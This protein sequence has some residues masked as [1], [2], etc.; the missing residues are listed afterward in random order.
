M[1]CSNCE[2][3]EFTCVCGA[4]V[5]ADAPRRE[6]VV[7]HRPGETCHVA[8]SVDPATGWPRPLLDRNAAAKRLAGVIHD[9]QDQMIDGH[10][11]DDAD[12]LADAVM[13]LARPMPTREEIKNAA[14]EAC[15]SHA[16][17]SVP[18]DLIAGAVLAL[19]DGAVG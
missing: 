4:L 16:Y 14:S 7:D 10:I 15:P 3:E 19:L 12:A 11:E 17:D 5:S 13:E 8:T 9:R 18:F 2:N 6:V 1:K